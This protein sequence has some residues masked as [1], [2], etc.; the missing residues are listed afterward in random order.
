MCYSVE[1]KG[2]HQCVERA[3]DHNCPVCL[4][5]LFDSREQARVMKC[6]HT[7]HQ[8]CFREYL[9][10]GFYTCPECSCSVVDMESYFQLLR[11]E[12]DSTPMPAG[13]SVLTNYICKDCHHQGSRAFHVVG[14]ECENCSSFNTRRI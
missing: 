10:A 14:L 1:L 5:Y 3:G 9:K 6:G 7:M 11:E 8:H 13:T 12:R 2:K 4:E